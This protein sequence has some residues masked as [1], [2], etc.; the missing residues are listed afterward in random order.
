METGSDIK[1]VKLQ[2]E[3]SSVYTSSISKFVNKFIIN[4]QM[5]AIYGIYLVVI[6]LKSIVV[7]VKCGEY[8]RRK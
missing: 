6:I 3:E 8:L 1:K 2:T 4:A 5:I 7:L